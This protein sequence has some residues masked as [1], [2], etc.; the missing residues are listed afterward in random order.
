MCG[1]AAIF[2]NASAQVPPGTVRA[3][4]DLVAHRGPDGEGEVF[5]DARGETVREGAPWQSGLGH[6]R[7]SI[8]DLSAAGRQPMRYRGLWVTYNGEIYNFVELRHELAQ[9]GHTFVSH[10][11]TEVLLAA[12]AEWGEHAFAR[13]RGMW[14]LV[15]VDAA[16]KRAL[17]CRDRLGIKPV[18]VWRGAGLLAVASEIKE[19]TALPQ[20]RL[21]PDEAAAVAYLSTGYEDPERTFL[22]RVAPVPAG[23]YQVLDLDALELGPPVSYWHPERVLVSVHDRDEAAA[24]FAAVFDESVRLHLRSDVPVGCALSGGLD[25]TSI[26]A[27]AGK[28][29]PAS[30]PPLHTFTATFPG[31]PVDE[32][33][34]VERLLASLPAA[35]PHWVT[36][37]AA[38]VLRDFDTFLWH[39]DEPV[40][41]LSQYAGYAIARLTREAGVP[42]T[43]NGQG[44][45]EV[46]S[47]YWQ[48]YFMHLRALGPLALAGHFFGALGGGNR[49]LWRQV[50]I[51]LRRF[52]ARKDGGAQLLPLRRPGGGDLAAG[53]IA[54]VLRASPQERRILELRAL[55]LP[56][57]LRWDD[58]NFMAFSV[59]GR[60][61]LLDHVLIDTCLQMAPEVLYDRGWIKEPLRRGL[62]G[63][64]PDAILRRRSKVGFE[65]PQAGW[66][67]GA[68]RPV[69]ER[70][71]ATDSPVW[72]F[73][74][75]RHARA[76]AAQ[77]FA[78]VGGPEAQQALFR[79]FCLQRWMTR[80]ESS[81][82]RA[83]A[84]A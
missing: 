37:T 47:G 31:D 53:I 51:M 6:R 67:R 56:R 14:A 22:A 80:F 21:E 43:L 29:R 69:V 61:P 77:V 52:R 50:P 72:R 11:D 79:L 28:L 16:R 24:R 15:L 75:P 81:R 78:G 83:S 20:V 71:L 33:P 25:S 18:H 7:L 39:H 23:H 9:L 13:L 32:R 76:L 2:R 46:L 82:A 1:I 27:L 40:G 73:V 36:P 59:E 57:L 45:D 60:Y 4:T 42:V 70:A 64:V 26:A 66:L 62:R 38:D 55:H 30:A 48:Y 84:Q 41:S 49:E 10:G 63:T 58:R 68:L 3:M 19:L 35:Q 34:W 74:E 12:Y 54:Q 8:L 17:I 65:T 5:L 44:G